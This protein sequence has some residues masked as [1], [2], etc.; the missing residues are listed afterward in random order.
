MNPDLTTSTLAWLERPHSPPI[1]AVVTI[2]SELFSVGYNRRRGLRLLTR[3]PSQQE[4]DTG[5][6]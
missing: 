1:R 6:P 3:I 4:L 5:A 2:R